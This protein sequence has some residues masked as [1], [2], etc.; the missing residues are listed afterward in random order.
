MSYSEEIQYNAELTDPWKLIRVRKATIVKKDGKEVG[1]QYH[2]HVKYPGD[3][4][5]QSDLTNAG[6]AELYC[7]D[8]EKIANAV[9]TTD[10]IN[11][12]AAEEKRQDDARKAGDSS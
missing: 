12:W 1:R 8:A 4:V 7:P 6:Q 10:V 9:W 3:K 2:R 11:A 5:S